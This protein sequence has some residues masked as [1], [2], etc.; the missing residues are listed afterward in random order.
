MQ[1]VDGAGF[2]IQCR[3]RVAQDFFKVGLGHKFCRAKAAKEAKEIFLRNA[4]FFHDSCSATVLKLLNV[5]M[6]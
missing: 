1:L 6:P 5:F 2:G 3:E 4:S